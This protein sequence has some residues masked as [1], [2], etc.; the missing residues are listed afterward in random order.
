MSTGLPTV[1]KQPL[2]R[3]SDEEIKEIFRLFVRDG[4]PRCVF[5]EQFA[6]TL[7]AAP[8]KDFLLLRPVS[9]ILIGKYDL[10]S[11]RHSAYSAQP[12]WVERRA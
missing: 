10:G 11:S 6:R 3:L 7:H 2:G 1:T 4:C 9:L 5:L 8:P 12:K